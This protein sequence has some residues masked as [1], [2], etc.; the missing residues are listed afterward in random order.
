[1][2]TRNGGVTGKTTCEFWRQKMME[3]DIPSFLKD[4]LIFF[5]KLYRARIEMG[6]YTLQ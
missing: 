4:L 6:G 1:M 5:Q 2:H 3:R